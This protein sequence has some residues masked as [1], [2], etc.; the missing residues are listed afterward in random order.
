MYWLFALRSG[1]K[2]LKYS[3]LL[4]TVTLDCRS[5]NKAWHW[6]G[7]DFGNGQFYKEPGTIYKNNIDQGL[8]KAI[9]LSIKVGIK[10]NNF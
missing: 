1:F 5:L 3:K 9:T 8:S 6:Y 2:T 10:I 4:G 7:Y